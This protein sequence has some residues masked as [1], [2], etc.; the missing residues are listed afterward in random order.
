MGSIAGRIPINWDVR[1]FNE[2]ASRR[3]ERFNPNTNS[4]SYKCIELENIDQGTGIVLGFVNSK[5]QASTKNTFYSGDVLFGKLRPYLRKYALM[6]Y[7][8]V[9][10]SEIW[11]LISQNT[12]IPEYLYLIVQ[13]NKFIAYSNKTSGTKMPRAEWNLVSEAMFHLPPL[14]EQ[15]K[16]AEIITTWD[17]AIA[18]TGKQIKAKERLKKGLMQQLLTGKMRFPGFPDSIKLRK[19]KYAEFPGDWDVRT[20]FNLGNRST[21]V[22]QTGPF[23]AQL[24]AS[25]YNEEGI[26][27]ILIRNIEGNRLNEENIPRISEKDALRL[28]KFAIQENDIVF[29]RVGRVGSC[30]IATKE[31]QGWIISGQTL[32]IRLPRDVV[33]IDYLSYAL[34]DESVRRYLSAISIGS[35]RKSISTETLENLPILMPSKN[36]QRKIADVLLAI[37]NEVEIL[38]KKVIAFNHQKQGLMQKLLTGEVRVKV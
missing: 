29:S 32:R 5:E 14:P 21:D 12:C 13:S 10:S 4:V 37:D 30:F 11:V 26:P 34:Q 27:L 19:A 35:T 28:K 25:D 16:I 1:P 31:H 20:V 8:G 6:D 38:Q 36:E 33:E 9:C 7:M 17:K 2:I 22:V 24:H 15:Q 23:G 3:K 18:L